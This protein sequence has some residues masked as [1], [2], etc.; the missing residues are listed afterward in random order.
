M[1]RLALYGVVVIAPLQHVGNRIRVG[2][3]RLGVEEG[4]FARNAVGGG[5]QQAL[6]GTLGR[7]L[8]E[9]LEGAAGSTILGIGPDLV[10]NLAVLLR[11]AFKKSLRGL[12][13]LGGHVEF[14]SLRGGLLVLGRGL[15]AA[16][17]LNLGFQLGGALLGSLL[18]LIHFMESSV[19]HRSGFALLAFLLRLL[20]LLDF[21]RGFFS[22]RR[23]GQNVAPIFAGLFV[24]GR[25]INNVFKF[26]VFQRHV[27]N[28]FL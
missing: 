27:S 16:K 17:A 22:L 12:F 7:D 19:R 3:R 6:R 18:R 21:G 14:F 8:L 9:L 23:V 13:L 26:I 4:V 2:F 25:K 24:L 1:Q 5:L 20:L 10:L 11:I 15:G 28:S